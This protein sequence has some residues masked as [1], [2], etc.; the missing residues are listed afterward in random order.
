MK[1]PSI[2]AGKTAVI[3][4]CAALVLMTGAGGAAAATA[5]DAKGVIT[6]SVLIKDNGPLADGQ[7]M[8]YNAA[9]GPPPEP[10][11]YE[12]TPDYVR[13]LDAN[14]RFEVELPAG[15]YYLR[16]VKRKSGER[17]GPPAA[18]DLVLR[19][20][21]ENGKPKAF[22]LE[23]GK[24]LDVGTLGG[25]EPLKTEMKHVISTAVEGRVVDRQGKPV[26][27]AVVVAFLKPAVMSKPL[28]ISEK[29]GK[30]GKYLLRLMPGTYYLR[31]R[32]QFASGPPEPG[33]IVGYYGE[34]QPAPI[35]VK[36]GQVL[37]GIDFGVI[38][39]P[40]RGPFSG[41]APAR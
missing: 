22:V 10:E 30:D 35:S 6:G 3:I 39:F 15:T 36:E 18:G 31:V 4:L 14:G 33:Q 27:D 26:P 17:I 7:V 16:A 20:N 21:G 32:N 37:T 19:I 41:G 8:F 40:G 12:R 24:K 5:S 1:N 23:A 38:L 28:F 34:G 11:K 9:S 29:T 13:D 2:F 25:A